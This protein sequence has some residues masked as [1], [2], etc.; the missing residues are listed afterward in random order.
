MGGGLGG[1][2]QRRSRA[3]TPSQIPFSIEEHSVPDTRVV[4]VHRGI[5]GGRAAS[6]T[7]LAV[8]QEEARL[9]PVSRPIPETAFRP[10]R[11]GETSARKGYR[12]DG[13]LARSRSGGCLG[14]RTHSQSA[15]KYQEPSLTR[16]R[17]SVLRKR[18]YSSLSQLRPLSHFCGGGL[19]NRSKEHVDTPTTH[20]RAFLAGRL[21]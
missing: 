20:A 5:R 10:L 13:S 4:R 8:V 7:T 15:P 1:S 12:T 3:L 14:D 21:L 16:G 2:R 11:C 6:A 19:H 18:D 17:P 9:P